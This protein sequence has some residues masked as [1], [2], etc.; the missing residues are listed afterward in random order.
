MNHEG[1]EVYEEEQNAELKPV[2]VAREGKFRLVD[3]REIERI[4]EDNLDF[5][6]KAWEAEKGRHVNG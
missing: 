1:H 2:K 6:M 3:L 5:L 4:I